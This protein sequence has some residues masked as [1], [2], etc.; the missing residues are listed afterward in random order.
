MRRLC[1]D[2]NALIYFLNGVEPYAGIVEGFLREARDGFRRVVV[3][4]VTE[5]EL[6]V[7][8]IRRDLKEEVERVEA[9]LSAPS[10]Q[11]IPLDRA[12]AKKAAQVRAATGLNLADAAIVATAMYAECE[13]IVGNDERCAQL[14]TDI[15]YVL[16]DALVKERQP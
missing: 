4:V 15:P 10:L 1:F 14:V 5:L 3:S 6:L 16:L 12:L 7:Q 2:T 8:P 13:A 9:L 11:V